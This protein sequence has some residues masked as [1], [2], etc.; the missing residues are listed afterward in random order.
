MVLLIIA[1]SLAILYLAL[2]CQYIY[3][4]WKIPDYGT[5]QASLTPVS[6]I[7]VTHNEAGN[8]ERCIRG[9]LSQHYPSHLYEV[10]VVDDHSTDDTVHRIQSI[11][12]TR[13]RVLELNAFPDAIHPP[14][15]KKSAITLGVNHAKHEL[16]LLTDADCM[17]PAN[18]L[19]TMV[20]HFEKSGSVFLAAPVIWLPGTSMLERLQ[21]TE[22]L[23]LMLITGSGIQSRLHLMANGANMAFSKKAF[24][25]VEGYAGNL[26]HASGDDMFLIE[27]MNSSFPK[28]ISFVKSRDAAVLTSGASGWDALLKQRIRWAGKNKGLK[29]PLIRIIWSFVGLYHIILLLTFLSA[30]F[31]F[32]VWWP[33]LVLLSFKWI[34]DYFLLQQAAFFFRKESVLRRFIPLQFFYTWYVLRMGWAMASG[35]EGDWRKADSE[36]VSGE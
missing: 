5:P 33:F 7:V 28:Q 29:S 30:L 4:W 21:E 20:H 23:T 11:S 19:R 34:A 10:I 24:I 1:L 8:V 31:T 6:I 27:K 22:M 3:F 2:L 26:H 13:L 15:Y 36:R 35:V 14:A 18:W 32:I 16:I 17:H 12:D 9:I 25:Q